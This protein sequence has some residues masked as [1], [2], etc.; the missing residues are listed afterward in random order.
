MHTFLFLYKLSYFLY[1]PSNFDLLD[2]LSNI[3]RSL[4][5][6]LG[7]LL[8]FIVLLSQRFLE[9]LDTPASVLTLV[10]TQ[11]KRN[12]MYY[13]SQPR[14]P[15]GSV[16][17]ILSRFNPGVRQHH[18]SGVPGCL[19]VNHTPTSTF[20]I[21]VIQVL[22]ALALILWAVLLLFFPFLVAWCTCGTRS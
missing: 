8:V 21:Q 5:P 15:F 14:E 22:L 10:P 6:H 2:T 1:F 20:K 9:T 4:I 19:E 18:S 3:P 16:R 12:N 7:P 11:A 13:V 17:Y